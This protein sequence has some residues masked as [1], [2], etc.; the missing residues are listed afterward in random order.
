MDAQTGTGRSLTR[1]GPC[2]GAA[3]PHHGEQSVNSYGLAESLGY[4]HLKDGGAYN[5][6][7]C[8]MRAISQ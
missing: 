7:P 4:V 3:R 8:L 1:S 2:C 5:S 6:T